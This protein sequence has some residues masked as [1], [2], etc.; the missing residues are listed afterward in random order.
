M[1][2]ILMGLYKWR[3]W[4]VLSPLHIFGWVEVGYSNSTCVLPR[5][6]LASLSHLSLS[7]E[8]TIPLT[9]IYHV[10]KYPLLL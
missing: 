9:G 6:S 8:L 1:K 2:G 3:F 7:L 5:L 10:A 4:R